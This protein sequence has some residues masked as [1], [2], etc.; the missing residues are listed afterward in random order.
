[1]LVLYKAFASATI[2]VLCFK[3]VR[4]FQTESLIDLTPEY[5]H[6]TD[7]H[8]KIHR[9][10]VYFIILGILCGLVG[11]LYISIQ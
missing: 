9:E 10:D 3:L 1:V 4:R 11:S 7:R 2:T 6:L 5:Y 8:H